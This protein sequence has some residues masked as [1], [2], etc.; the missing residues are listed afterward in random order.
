MRTNRRRSE[1]RI[2]SLRTGERASDRSIFQNSTPHPRVI[3]R[4]YNVASIHSL[5][6]RRFLY[7]E[8]ADS[9]E[10]TRRDWTLK[11][12]RY[13]RYYT[14]L[15][16]LVLLLL[17]LLLLLP[18]ISFTSRLVHLVSRTTCVHKGRSS[19]RRSASCDNTASSDASLTR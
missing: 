10:T 9:Q 16:L 14:L 17:L 15:L 7:G 1:P 2:P 12:Y 6:V 8:R 5:A 19:V 11:L 18:S 3:S 4:S 13:Y